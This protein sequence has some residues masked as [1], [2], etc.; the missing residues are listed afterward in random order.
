MQAT[1]DFG[2]PDADPCRMIFPKL[3]H[4]ATEADVTAANAIFSL[5]AGSVRV[6]TRPSWPAKAKWITNKN[7]PLQ[8]QG[9]TDA[10]TGVTKYFD[11][12]NNQGFVWQAEEI[13][14][15]GK[16]KRYYGFVGAHAV[17]KVAAEEIE[18]VKEP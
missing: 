11:E 10:K 8:V 9:E 12:F 17:A 16:W 6:V 4:P 13:Q 2:F 1:L 15:D 5:G 7:Y 18:F 14:V 3:D